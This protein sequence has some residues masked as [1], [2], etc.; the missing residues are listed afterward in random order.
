MRN[1]DI[2]DEVLDKR[3]E[4]IEMAE[5]DSAAIIIDCLCEMVK[6]EREDKKFYKDLY[7]LYCRTGATIA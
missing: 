4:Y 1:I 7:A 3:G 6:K 2:L 5:E